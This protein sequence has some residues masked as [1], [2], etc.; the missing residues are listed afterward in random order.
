M[1]L[2]IIYS[3]CHAYPIEYFLNLSDEFKSNYVCH[4]VSILKYLNNQEI[5]QL[6][7]LDI[8]K[9]KIADVIICQHIQTDRK[10]LNHDKILSYCKSDV[11]V[12]MMPHHRFS[13]YSFISKNEFKFKINH[14]T[15]ISNDI[16][17][18]YLTSKTYKEFESGFDNV[19]KNVSIKMDDKE[20]TR[21]SNYFIDQYVKL[22]ENQSS[23]EIN[24]AKFVIINYKFCQLFADDSH[25]TGLFFYELTRKILNFLGFFKIE[26][27]SQEKDFTRLSNSIW[28]QTFIPL[29]EQE[30]EKLELRFNCFTPYV[31]MIDANTRKKTNS[32]CEYYYSHIQNSLLKKFNENQ[33]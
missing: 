15:F 14:W 21:F 5:T 17:D 8:S 29:L 1:K 7:D 20:V 26:P 24:M 30:K 16:Y 13:G 31:V 2:V 18:H 3:N 33:F 23:E 9:L 10:Y 32:L 25:P 6:N 19:I 27:Y 12:L 28:L 11:K 4:I 22:N